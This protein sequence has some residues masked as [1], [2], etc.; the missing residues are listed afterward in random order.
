MPIGLD[1]IKKPTP[2]SLNKFANWYA[3]IAGALLAALAA[4][5]PFDFSAET[6]RK[7]TWI[8][9]LSITLIKISTPFVGVDVP[10]NAK[11]SVKDVDV[12]DTKK[13]G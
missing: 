9:G 13:D 8:L 10:D 12:L 7:I 4:D 6:S 11:V 2:A 5:N 3:G 1:Q